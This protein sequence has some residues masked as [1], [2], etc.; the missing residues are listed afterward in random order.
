MGRDRAPR[1]RA[2]AGQPKEA[3]MTTPQSPQTPDAGSTSTGASKMNT[4]LK[5]IPLGLYIVLVVIVVLAVVIMLLSYAVNSAG[6]NPTSSGTSNVE[7]IY[8][9]EMVPASTLP[10]DSVI[11]NGR[12]RCADG[13]TAM[14][15]KA[16]D[17]TKES[18]KGDTV[19]ANWTDDSVIVKV[20]G[21]PIQDR[22]AGFI[23]DGT[24]TMVAAGM[25]LKS[26]ATTATYT[27]NFA[28]GFKPAARAERVTV[29]VITAK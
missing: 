11:F 6:N 13:T 12:L 24:T 29:C 23:Y 2:F 3:E 17:K 18:P 27:A 19:K 8:A 9:Q 21:K 10:S 15:F 14:T 22:Y 28:D 5:K 16:G 4:M 1:A 26:D 25:E 7:V 20:T